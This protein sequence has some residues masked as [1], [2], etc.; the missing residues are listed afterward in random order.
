[1]NYESKVAVRGLPT[2]EHWIYIKL[3]A[4]K[5]GKELIT[6]EL[7]AEK[8]VATVGLRTT[9]ARITLKIAPTKFI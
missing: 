8:Y 1:M 3:S 2:L 4:V 9:E 7:F 5:E 6:N